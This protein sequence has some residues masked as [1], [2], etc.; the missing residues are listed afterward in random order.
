MPNACFAKRRVDF[1][2]ARAG[3]YPAGRANCIHLI[4]SYLVARDLRLADC[5]VR[6]I[7]LV[8]RQKLFWTTERSGGLSPTPYSLEIIKSIGSHLVTGCV[9]IFT[10]FCKK[11]LTLS[12][13]SDQKSW[14]YCSSPINAFFF[15]FVFYFPTML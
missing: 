10:F 11:R 6:K 1:V 2:L 8:Y 13:N 7:T 9:K 4:V 5:L 12:W 15:I 14:M 3:K